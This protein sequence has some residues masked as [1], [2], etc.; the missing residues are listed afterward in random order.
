M[1]QGTKNVTHKSKFEDYEVLSTYKRLKTWDSRAN[2]T[3]IG[4][5]RKTTELSSFFAKLGLKTDAS[6]RLLQ[7]KKKTILINSS[8]KGKRKIDSK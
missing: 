6:E 2:S 1:P 4:S 3:K 5:I 8:L 7:F